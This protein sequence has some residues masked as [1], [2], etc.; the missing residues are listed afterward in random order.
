M[1]KDCSRK[2]GQLGLDPTRRDEIVEELAQQLESA[3]NEEVARGTAEPEA[4]R[5]SLEQFRDWDKLRTEVSES[6]RGTKLPVWQQNGITA[7][8][9]PLVWMALAVALAFSALPTFRKGSDSLGRRRIFPA[10]L[11]SDRGKRR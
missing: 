8:R 6:V 4:A 5:R 9:R 2:P 1:E 11:A 10:S 3:Y 7:P